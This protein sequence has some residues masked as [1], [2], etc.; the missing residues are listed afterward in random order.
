[1][2]GYVCSVCVC[3]RVCALISCPLM[4]LSCP[5]PCACG[6]IHKALKLSRVSAICSLREP[7]RM[8]G[9]RRTGGREQEMGDW[10]WWGR[11]WGVEGREGEADE[12]MMKGVKI[13]GRAE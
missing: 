8:A 12:Q 4:E 7:G 9:G 13:G 10:R 3:V 2:W 11:G 5:S 6:I 1:M